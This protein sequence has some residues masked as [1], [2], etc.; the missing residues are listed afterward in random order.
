M[1]ADAKRYRRNRTSAAKGAADVLLGV[2]AEEAE[3]RV[4]PLGPL[5]KKE[6]RFWDITVQGLPAD[7]F[8]AHELPVLMQYVRV[9]AR[10]D[11]LTEELEDSE[12]TVVD[13][14][15]HGERLNPVF[16]VMKHLAGTQAQLSRQLRLT[17]GATKADGQKTRGTKAVPEAPEPETTPVKQGRGDLLFRPNGNGS[18]AK[19]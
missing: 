8:F 15:T 14:H 12:N 13:D 18:Q 5:S 3:T 19:H 17:I 4:K 2:A 6:R 10:L 16:N 7:H 9:V 1:T 11:T